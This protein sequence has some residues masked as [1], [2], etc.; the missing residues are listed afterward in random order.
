MT[1][2]IGV[3][4]DGQWRG[5][6]RR[7]EPQPEGE[8]ACGDLSREEEADLGRAH[9]GQKLDHAELRVDGESR[10][11]TGGEPG[12]CERAWKEGQ[13]EGL[14]PAMDE[15]QT[16]ARDSEGSGLGGSRWQGL[17]GWLLRPPGLTQS[18]GV[19]AGLGT[20][21]LV[22]LRSPELRMW[23]LLPRIMAHGRE[24]KS[25]SRPIPAS[26]WSPRPAPAGRGCLPQP[27]TRRAPWLQ[28]PES[29]SL[30]SGL[31]RPGLPGPPPAISSPGDGWVP[32]RCRTVWS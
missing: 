23:G 1:V 5:W 24:A 31:P 20:L 21:C 3:P 2:G 8:G 10:L 4:G 26:R 17:L 32:D 13:L 9:R 30:R 7:D 18:S 15:S 29:C 11:S 25:L 22:H 27:P 19:V 12:L 16:W 28:T 14:D 6:R